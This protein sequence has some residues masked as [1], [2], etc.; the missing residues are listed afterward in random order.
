M[1]QSGAAQA[2]SETFAARSLAAGAEQ[3]VAAQQERLEAMAAA[4]A[5]LQKEKDEWYQQR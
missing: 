4:L 1:S 5:A 3:T 2:A